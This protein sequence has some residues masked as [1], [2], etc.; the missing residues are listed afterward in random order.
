MSKPYKLGGALV[1]AVPSG[2]MRGLCSNLIERT[3]ATGH[4]MAQER[5][6]EVNA[7]IAHWLATSVADFWPLPTAAVSAQDEA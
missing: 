5:P 3:I 6:V 2:P 4:W 1:E 7:A